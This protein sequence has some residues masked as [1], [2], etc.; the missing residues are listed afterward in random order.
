MA[1]DG[2]RPQM[3]VSLTTPKRAAARFEGPHHY[4]GGRFVPPAIV[5]RAQRTLGLQRAGY[6]FGRFEA[7]AW[8]YCGFDYERCSCSNCLR[9][10]LC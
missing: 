1:G 6:M 4:L 8:R 9:K 7:V 3:L 2:L 10:H 5:V